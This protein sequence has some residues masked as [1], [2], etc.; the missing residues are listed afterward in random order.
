MPAQ[1]PADFLS[2]RL[3]VFCKLPR[4]PDDFRHA[5]IFGVL[6][7]VPGCPQTLPERRRIIKRFP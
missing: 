7:T 6:S 3:K 2:K 4:L 5:R 1:D